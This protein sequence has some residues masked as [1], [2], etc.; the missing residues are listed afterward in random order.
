MGCRRGP[1]GCQLPRAV[2]CRARREAVDQIALFSNTSKLSARQNCVAP[3]ASLLLLGC[4]HQI[5]EGRL[6]KCSGEPLDLNSTGAALPALRSEI[7]GLMWTL[8]RGYNSTCV[9][10]L[11]EAGLYNSQFSFIVES[12][13]R[14]FANSPHVSRYFGNSTCRNFINLYVEQI[15]CQGPSLP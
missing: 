3:K 8:R 13:E 7:R 14:S 2:F 12:A 5:L 10:I 11:E 4:S 9:K 1:L 15:D 6:A